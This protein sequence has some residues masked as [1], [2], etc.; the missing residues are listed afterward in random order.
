MA[1][2]A[3]PTVGNT[4]KFSNRNQKKLAN[5]L[6]ILQ[7]ICLEILLVMHI[8]YSHDLVPLLSQLPQHHLPQLVPEGQM[9]KIH[10]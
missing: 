9:H 7:V 4:Y 1:L 10:H 3:F 2:N 6:Y 8:N 5:N